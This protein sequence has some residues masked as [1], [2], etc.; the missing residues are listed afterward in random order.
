MK[1]IFN[2]AIIILL[3]VWSCRP[4]GDP[5]NDMAQVQKCLEFFH[6]LETRWQLA[7]RIW[8]IL[9]SLIHAEPVIVQ[10]NTQGS[11]QYH[12]ILPLR[13]VM[14]HKHTVICSPAK[15]WSPFKA[16][17]LPNPQPELPQSPGNELPQVSQQDIQSFLSGFD[18]QVSDV[19]LVDLLSSQIGQEDNTS[20][21]QPPIS[22][23]VLHQPFYDQELFDGF[24]LP[25]PL[26]FQ[27]LNAGL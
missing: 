25:P 27:S 13:H 21:S 4:S 11:K 26:F 18:A 24:T 2:C 22:G 3:D 8:D 23:E 5:D 6:S 7:G 15:R 12:D 10:S 19:T 9:H 1:P 20:F 16:P 14:R 17:A